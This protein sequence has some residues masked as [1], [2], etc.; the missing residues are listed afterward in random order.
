MMAAACPP[1]CPPARHDGA[2]LVPGDLSA[3][4]MSRPRRRPPWRSSGDPA[5]ILV[6]GQ[7]SGAQ[8]DGR[9]GHIGAPLP[10][11]PATRAVGD[12]DEADPSLG[13]SLSRS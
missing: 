3:I 9:Q 6:A 10:L 11:R 12:P 7:V 13:M 1:A 5:D 8:M 2:R 4:G